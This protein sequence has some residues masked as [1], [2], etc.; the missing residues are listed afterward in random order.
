M[1]YYKVIFEILETHDT[2]ELLVYVERELESDILTGYIEMR[3]FQLF[4]G[5]LPYLN[6]LNDFKIIS[7][8]KD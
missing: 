8:K 4:G 1:N 7:I 2:K 6:S 3:I 5:K